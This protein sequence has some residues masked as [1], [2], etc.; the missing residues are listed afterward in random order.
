[1]LAGF[2]FTA[3]PLFSASSILNKT[4]SPLGCSVLLD[5]FVAVCCCFGAVQF[6]CWY[7]NWLTI[8]SERKENICL[9]W[10]KNVLC[11]SHFPGFAVTHQ[12]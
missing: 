11:C 10:L 6:A 8:R 3:L 4:P 1:M 2:I 12:N 9:P 5:V 7:F